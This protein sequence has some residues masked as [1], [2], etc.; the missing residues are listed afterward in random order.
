MDDVV[1]VLETTDEE[2]EERFELMKTKVN[3]LIEDWK[4]RDYP[5]DRKLEVTVATRKNNHSDVWTERYNFLDGTIEVYFVA[6]V[7]TKR[8]DE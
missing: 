8:E 4:V 7:G 1:K 2:F 5:K 3:Q 6:E